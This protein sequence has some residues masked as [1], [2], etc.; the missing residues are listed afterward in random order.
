MMDT[1]AAYYRIRLVWAIVWR[2]AAFIAAVC[3][4]LWLTGCAAT[5]LDK[6]ASAEDRAACEAAVG[7]YK[8]AAWLRAYSDCLRAKGYK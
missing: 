7:A 1:I 3:A 8:G 4:F 2:W 5:R 6:Q